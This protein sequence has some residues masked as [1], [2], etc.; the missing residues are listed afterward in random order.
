MITPPSRP[1]P[2]RAP[3][4]AQVVRADAGKAPMVAAAAALILMN[5]APAVAGLE[6]DLLA[7]TE[8]NKALNEKVRPPSS[9]KSLH[10]SISSPDRA[11]TLPAVVP[12]RRG[13]PPR[14][15]TS[16]ARGR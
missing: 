9:P 6:E 12:R 4:F 1:I 10:R 16:P 13:S 15:P 2:H 3:T 8:A 11:A 7:R 5:A 14:T